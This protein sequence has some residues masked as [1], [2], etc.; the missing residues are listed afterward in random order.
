M[1]LSD[2]I[3]HGFLTMIMVAFAVAIGERFQVV[4]TLMLTWKKTQYDSL[5]FVT[6]GEGFIA[7]ILIV[8]ATWIATSIFYYKLRGQKIEW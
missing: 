4:P 5:D 8:E 3:I 2:I 6:T 7:L 1:K